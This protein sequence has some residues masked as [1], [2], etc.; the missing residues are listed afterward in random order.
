[1]AKGMTNGKSK[2][3]RNFYYY[4]PTF[5]TFMPFDN[6]G[7]IIIDEEHESSYRSDTTPKYDAR[8]VQG[9]TNELYDRLFV[10][11][12]KCYTR[13]SYLS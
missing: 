4:W 12:G 8:E 7:M 10:V 1:M 13:F 11:D 9:N 2:R 6:L 3:K 5:C